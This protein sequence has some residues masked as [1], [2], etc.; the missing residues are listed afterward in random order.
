MHPRSRAS[1]TAGCACRACSDP[2]NP[3]H[4]INGLTIEDEPGMRPKGLPAPKN[5]PFYTLTTHDIEGARAGWKP[6]HQMGGIQE[7]DRR[8]F[9]NI[10]FVSDIEGTAAGSKVNG[11]RTKRVTDPNNPVY[12]L[13]DGAV[14]DA[15]RTAPTDQ[16]HLHSAS[17]T[18]VE[19]L[20]RQVESLKKDLEITRL[21]AEISRLKGRP[22]TG[23]SGRLTTAGSYSRGSVRSADRMV[24]RSADGRPRVSESPPAGGQGQGSGGDGGGLPP[25]GRSSRRDIA[26]VQRAPKDE[27]RLTPAALA[28]YGGGPPGRGTFGAG[29]AGDAASVASY[30]SAAS[31]RS[32]HSAYSYRSRASARSRARRQAEQAASRRGPTP[33]QRRAVAMASDD[34]NMIQ[35]LPDRPPSAALSRAGSASFR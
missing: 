34:M 3:R 25:T 13:L 11:M 6:K 29:P 30:A 16:R 5:A 23:Q 31:V 22:A 2:L 15:P 14:Y 12:P 9:R 32:V 21:Q 7:E 33:Q 27:G 24:L 18:E 28:Q 20:R 17:G 4:T 1:L 19:T 26:P 35:A 8:H 10:N